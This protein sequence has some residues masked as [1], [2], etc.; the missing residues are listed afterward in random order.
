MKPHKPKQISLGLCATLIVM[1]I[2]LTFS[3]TVLL[4][5]GRISLGGDSA[6]S[7]YAKLREIDQLAQNYFYKDPDNI[8]LADGVA[9]GY[10]AGLGDP[11]AT[12]MTAEQYA[13][14]MRS[15][16][17]VGIGIGITTTEHPDTHFLYVVSVSPG[18]PA[19]DAD[20]Q[21]GDQI[22]AV[23]GK[24]VQ[25]LGYA[26]AVDLI[27]GEEGT[28][29]TLTVLRE[30]K[31]HA[32]TLTRR[33]YASSSVESRMVG[34]MGYVRITSF[35]DGTVDQ[36]KDAVNALQSQG[37]AGLMFDVRHNTGG[38]LDSVAAML[39]FLLPE[40]DLVS[41]VYRDGKREVLHRSDASQINLPMAVLTDEYSASASELFA[42]AIRDFGK[43]KL[44]G[45]TT[46]GKGIMQ[47]TYE[48]SDKS[49]VRFTIAEFNPPSGENFNGKGLKPDVE[50]SLTDDQKLRFYLLTD[51]EDSVL[52]AGLAVLRGN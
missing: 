51:E 26:N 49:A 44:V 48:L 18:S 5:S 41:A 38:T 37:A 15:Y 9:A 39:D 12:Y 28:D 32:V 43:G 47:R 1:A 33:E 14:M 24:D 23:D 31:S 25:S 10:T 45:E 35:N 3:V 20:I 52:Q 2:S 22:T 17:G 46:F 7:I 29:C 50:V 42:A 13:S 11:Y 40:G 16:E 6:Q 4:T 30:G 21:K 8:A 19:A 27:L 36:F 34:E